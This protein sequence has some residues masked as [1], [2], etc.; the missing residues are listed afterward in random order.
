MK[1][2]AFIDAENI[3]QRLF[4]EGCSRLQEDHELVQIDVFGKVCPK[5]AA[6]HNYVRA[7]VGKNSADTFMTAAIVRAI[8]EEAEIGGG[9]TFFPDRERTGERRV[10]EEGRERGG[11][12]G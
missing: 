1:I 6:G 5:W 11:E 3:S 10:G 2:H 7:F 8:Y 12:W 4:V 9:A